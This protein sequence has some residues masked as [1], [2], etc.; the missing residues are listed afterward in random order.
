MRP[1]MI[2]LQR[3]VN[4]SRYF[5]G[6]ATIP[7][8]KPGQTRAHA[9]GS[10]RGANY[11]LWE[12]RHGVRDASNVLPSGVVYNQLNSLAGPSLSLSTPGD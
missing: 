9:C 8:V 6:S 7:T 12:G 3:Y 5:K 1:G 4:G 10:K 2:Q 11:N